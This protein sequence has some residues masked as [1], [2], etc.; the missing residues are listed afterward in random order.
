MSKAK[1]ICQSLRFYGENEVSTN[2]PKQFFWILNTIVRHDIQQAKDILGPEL[3]KGLLTYAS[4]YAQRMV[5][6]A[7]IFTE[8]FVREEYKNWKP[9]SDNPRVID[10]GGD[11]GAVSALYWKY[12]KPNA[13]ITVVEANPATAATMD[14]NISRKG[15]KDIEII[16]AAISSTEGTTALTLHKPGKGW[17]TQDFVRDTENDDQFGYRVGV[18]K[19]VLSSLI[20]DGEE[21]DLI[22]IDIEGAETDAIYDLY[23]SKKLNQ[24]RQILME[25][26]HDRNQFPENDLFN[27]LGIL[28]KSGFVIE[29]LHITN[30][31]GLRAKSKVSRSELDT[32]Y[33]TEEKAFITFSAI[34]R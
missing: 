14:E 34:R 5:E 19:L 28:E 16:N 4:I 1:E 3:E 24:V 32:I 7:Y 30:G 26:H 10:L 15:I 33:R 20:Y 13:V 8:V 17:H 9:T 21:V 29:D 23:Q 11:P 12:R 6:M 27:M 18:P 25:F 31:S 2:P 22:K